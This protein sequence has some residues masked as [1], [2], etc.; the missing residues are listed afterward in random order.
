MRTTFRVALALLL[1][2]AVGDYA[3]GERAIPP[4]HLTVGYDEEGKIDPNPKACLALVRE[5]TQWNEADTRKGA[6]EVCAAR[7]KHGRK[8]RAA[9]ECVFGP[10]AKAVGSP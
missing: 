1:S 4:G 5:M 3:L 10:A 2:L 7:K 8:A 6:L 9:R